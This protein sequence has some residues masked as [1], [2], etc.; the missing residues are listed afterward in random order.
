MERRLGPVVDL[1]SGDR[2]EVGREGQEADA[3][4]TRNEESGNA[5][6]AKLSIDTLE[7]GTPRPRLPML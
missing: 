1:D 3:D 5:L 7:R 6:H 4:A 2:H